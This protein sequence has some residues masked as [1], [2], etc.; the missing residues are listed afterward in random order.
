[1]IQKDLPSL[2]HFWRFNVFPEHRQNK[3]DTSLRQCRVQHLIRLSV[4]SFH[5]LQPLLR[6]WQLLPW[7][8]FCLLFAWDTK[9][10]SERRA[11]NQGGRW[12]RG[13]H[14]G[15]GRNNWELRHLASHLS[16]KFAGCFH[17]SWLSRP[18][19]YKPGT[20]CGSVCV[21]KSLSEDEQHRL[22]AIPDSLREEVSLSFAN[23][24]TAKQ[25]VTSFNG[26]AGSKNALWPLD[27]EA[28]PDAWRKT[29]H[30]P[31]VRPVRLDLHIGRTPQ[32]AES[33][34]YGKFL[35]EMRSAAFIESGCSQRQGQNYCN[36]KGPWFEA[37]RGCKIPVHGLQKC[38]Q[39]QRLSNNRLGGFYIWQLFFG[40]LVG[41]NTC[42]TFS[43]NH[44]AKWKTPNNIQHGESPW[45]S[46]AQAIVCIGKVFV[47]HIQF[48]VTSSLV[49]IPHMTL[50]HITTYLYRSMIH[51]NRWDRLGSE[52]TRW[53]PLDGHKNI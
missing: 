6:V 47:G 43:R 40:R 9:W 50:G 46:L 1:M 45:S 35:R 20:F 41:R 13:A 24:L 5:H 27:A 49:T 15:K 29:L 19:T 17:E 26:T 2:Q 44:L 7:D 48:F 37:S 11:E 30:T 25:K 4:P 32:I 53:I 31:P 8:Q 38:N 34:A 16:W 3:S 23:N 28:V 10:P 22:L 18:C 42:R 12:R 14:G 51:S 36:S 21:L 33:S 39:G 52:K